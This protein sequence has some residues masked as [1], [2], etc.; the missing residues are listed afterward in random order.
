MGV[1]FVFLFVN[2][3]VH[4]YA[5]CVSVI[6]PVGTQ[7]AWV[8][9]SDIINTHHRHLTCSNLLPFPFAC[10]PICFPPSHDVLR[11]CRPRQYCVHE[12]APFCCHSSCVGVG[13]RVDD[14]WPLLRTPSSSYR[15][16]ASAACGGMLCE[17]TIDEAYP[18]SSAYTTSAL[19]ASSL[20]MLL[21]TH[22]LLHVHPFRCVV[23][24]TE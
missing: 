19:P 21:F 2:V 17:Y 23:P 15:A 7:G 6:A 20:P 5:G 4:T 10:F 11:R 22:F 9:W 18:D 16:S 14:V 8:L 3:C 12:I 1:D 24:N 13:V